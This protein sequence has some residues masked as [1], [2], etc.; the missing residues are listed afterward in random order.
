MTHDFSNENQSTVDTVFRFGDFELDPTNRQLTH[1]GSPLSLQPKA[2]DALLLL[3][4]RAEQLVPKQELIATLWP[5]V[6]VSDANL[7]NIIVSLR[8]VVG[9]DAIRTV[10][11]YGYRFEL[12]VSGTPGMSRTT[13]ERFV[14]AKQLAA[15]RSLQSMT[16][17]RDH[18]WI[19]IAENPSFAPGWAW[20]GRCSWFLGKFSGQKTTD[21]ELARA[22]FD[23]AMSLDPDHAV[24]HQFLTLMQVDTG[25]AHEAVLR[26]LKRVRA[27]LAEPESFS[28]LV[29]AFRFRGLL[30]LSVKAHRRAT[31]IDPAIITSLPHTLF[32]RGEFA[33]AIDS[34]GG[35]GAFYLDAASWAAL[36]DSSRAIMLLRERLARD[37]LS[38]L[39]TALMSSLL[40]LL[41]ERTSFAILQ[42]QQTDASLDPEI[43]FYFARH[44][45]R[46]GQSGMAISALRRAAASGFICAPATLDGDPWLA[47]LGGH[48]ELAAVR[49]NAARQ[50][51]H[52]IQ[53]VTPLLTI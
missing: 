21:V 24:T 15:Q 42:M 16:L 30:D 51:E 14:R 17:A 49:E 1:S 26:L 5:S 35:R 9:R 27:Y 32:L 25:Q 41:E 37:P 10:S 23:R 4:R 11:K 34:Y 45:S 48:P 12:P 6:H 33:S 43:Q 7:T 40:A 28:G 22:A 38:P 52:E 20:L 29:Q 18:L 3:V 44:Y 31:E 19:C 2:F 46:L 50:I 36:G 39:M 47:P 53:S 13:F 8:K